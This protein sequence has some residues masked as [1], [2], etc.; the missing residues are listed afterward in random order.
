VETDVHET[1]NLIDEHPDKVEKM[2]DALTRWSQELQYPGIFGPTERS[3]K[4]WF[5]FYFESE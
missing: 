2:K 3:A 4:P 5:D 1:E